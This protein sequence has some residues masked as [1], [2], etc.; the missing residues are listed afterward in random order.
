MTDN[1]WLDL[2]DSSRIEAGSKLPREKTRAPSMR[3]NPLGKS[4]T[5]ASDGEY[6][7]FRRK[8]AN[9]ATLER[10]ERF[11]RS[12]DY[13]HVGTQDDVEIYK[14][15]PASPFKRKEPLDLRALD[16]YNVRR[17]AALSA[18][19]R[20]WAGYVDALEELAGRIK[21]TYDPAFA[22]TMFGEALNAVEN[23]IA[24]RGGPAKSEIDREL[25]AVRKRRGE[26]K[27]RK[28]LLPV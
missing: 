4:R 9:P 6:V 28:I 8:Q 20:D 10:H 25:A 5:W 11:L 21:G 14:L 1:S 18:C 22:K 17:Q 23:S 15:Q 12:G 19:R 16:M 13:A 24:I 2:P 26:G 27:D 7:W 3:K